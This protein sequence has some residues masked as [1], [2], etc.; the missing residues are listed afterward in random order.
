M[1]GR[2]PRLERQLD[3]TRA[4]AQ[5]PSDGWLTVRE[6]RATGPLL[7]GCLETIC[8]HLKGSTA[9]VDPSGAV[10]FLETSEE[11]P[12]PAYVDSYLSDL[13]QLGVFDV[14]AGLVVA[15]PYGYSPEDAETLWEV[16][17]RRS[18]QAG[19]PVLGN[20]DCGHTDP[21]LTLP[22]GVDAEL[23]AGAR[24][25]RLLEAPTTAS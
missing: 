2:V 19:I 16:V 21:M 10:L 17:A 22:I 12:P 8:W 13:E 6:G 15:R 3:L 20:V 1:D 7:G 25:L 5:R 14:A 9:W 24:T 23:D 18:G 4:R 11:A